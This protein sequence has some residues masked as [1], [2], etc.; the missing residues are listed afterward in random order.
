MKNFI[1]NNVITVLVLVLFSVMTVG[2][3]VYGQTLQLNGKV[4]LRGNGKIEITS[5]TI[6]RDESANLSSYSNPTYNEM[7]LSFNITGTSTTFYA[8]YLIEI[9][10]NSL[11]DYTMMDFN[12]SLNT[13][14]DVSM[15]TMIT[16][17][18]TGL[19]M[20]P[21][22]GFLSGTVTVLK[23]RLDFES[24]NTDTN[25]LV[26]G[27]PDVSEEDPGTIMASISPLEG[28][29]RDNEIECFTL[30][31]I[32]SY[33]YERTF[34]LSSSNENILLVDS[35]RNEIG[36][37]I[38]ASGETKEYSVCAIVKDG[39]T[40]YNDTANTSVLLHSNGRSDINAGNL[41]LSVIKDESG[42]VDTT[43]PQV[44]NVVL[45]ITRGNSVN[46]N[47]DLTWTK[48]EESGYAVSN[49]H[50]IL[51]NETTGLIKEYE[52]GNNVPSYSFVGLDEGTYNAKVYGVDEAGN[53]G[54]SY[55][56][57]ATTDSGYCS[58][59]ASVSLKWIF[60]V[61]NNFTN[62]TSSGAATVNIYD[63][64]TA[65]L[66]LGTDATTLP[67][68]ITVTMGG[69]TLA[70]SQYEY[71]NTTGVY[72]IKDV[73]GDLVISANT[74]CLVEG[75]RIRIT[76]GTT[77]KI[78]DIK[79]DDLLMVFDHENGGVTYEYPIWIEKA[80]R[81][82]SYQENSFSDG[83]VL[84]TYG[85][86]GV[87]SMDKYE[88][89]SVTDKDSF[90]VGTKVAKI[91]ED[92]SIEVVIVTDIKTIYKEVNYYHVSST[93]YHNVIAEDLLTTDGTLV[94]SNMFSFNKDITWSSER[95]NFLKKND[96]FYYEDWKHY[97]PEHIFKGYRMEEA[98]NV[99][100]KGLLDIEE[101]YYNLKNLGSDTMKNKSG[102]TVWMVTTSDD[103][104]KN[105]NNYLRE[106]NSYYQLKEPKNKRN[107]IGWYNTG[108]G[109]MYYPGDK[110]RVIY[111]MHFIAKYN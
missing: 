109:K 108:D 85:D 52:T 70:S 22:D 24:T 39:A 94:S 75:T 14:T 37:L 111:G 13:G 102:D 48:V 49:Y 23:V 65:T 89:V 36:N 2:F 97:F 92:G 79:Y 69:Q 20:S 106:Q 63:T 54:S 64:Y 30:S 28:N 44:S 41:V 104:V 58:K 93:R 91:I 51:E 6:L 78:E 82:M 73:T 34:W 101:Y 86:H 67:T 5:A 3:A 88:Y 110:V 43:P 77:K 100:N 107:F 11:F 81:V 62:V 59:S 25:V 96:L 16:N 7:D 17:N 38:I 72:T 47:A 71:S 10:N 9:T 80:T 35:S 21:G 95:D 27:N 74:T 40:F 90:H 66:S 12:L 98:K 15:T 42:V 53:S 19:V 87:F 50:I 32:S 84:N 103:V 29:L 18:K 46:G 61:T 55:C 60:S 83:T 68:S 76:D 33:K 105:K 8:T 99:F 45:E 31:V 26:S 56:T 1:K 4:N 57:D